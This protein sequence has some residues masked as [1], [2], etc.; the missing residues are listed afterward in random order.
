MFFDF[1]FYVRSATMSIHMMLGTDACFDRYFFGH[2][3]TVSPLTVGR[4]KWVKK[5]GGAHPLC[6]VD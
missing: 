5:C 3:I 6:V 1:G 2:G 4:W